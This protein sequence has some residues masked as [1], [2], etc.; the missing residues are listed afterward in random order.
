MKDTIKL[1]DG[2]IEEFIDL[3]IEVLKMILLGLSFEEIKYSLNEKFQEFNYDIISSFFS[4]LHFNERGEVVRAYPISPIPTDIEI[5]VEGLGRGYAM[6]AIDSLGAAYLFGAKVEIYSVDSTTGIP[7]QIMIDPNQFQSESVPNVIVTM[8]K[9]V[10]ESAFCCPHVRFLSLKGSEDIPEG[11]VS[12]GDA[13]KY[14]VTFF[15]RSNMR[16]KFRS[17][18]LPLVRLYN[19]ESLAVDELTKLYSESPRFNLLSSLFPNDF[20]NI[21]VTMLCDRGVIE[22]QEALEGARIVLT[23][24]G[25]RILNTFCRC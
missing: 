5:T 19:S 18:L 16:R 21:M 24:K 11:A 17:R 25:K 23:P 20:G 1:K 6:C 9:T 8:P 12:F 22:Q 14:G 13:M 2:I 4:L 3:H 15:G 7:I 10:E